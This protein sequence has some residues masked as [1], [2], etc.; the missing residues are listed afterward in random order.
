M[1]ANT[2]ARA[3]KSLVSCALVLAA[4]GHARADLSDVALAKSE[5]ASGDLLHP[6]L[7]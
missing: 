7:L 6:S 4:A 5:G 1:K 2:I 3:C